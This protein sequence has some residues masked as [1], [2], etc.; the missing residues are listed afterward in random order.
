MPEVEH[1]YVTYARNLYMWVCVG[2]CGV[3]G[4]GGGGGGALPK[5]VHTP[6]QMCSC[7]PDCTHVYP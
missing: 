1:S 6:Q 2:V 4:R 3:W 5:I 7:A